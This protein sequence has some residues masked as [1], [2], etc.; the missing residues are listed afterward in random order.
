MI[1][2]V[3]RE[4][5]DKILFSS[6]IKG[7]F[8]CC[9]CGNPTDVSFNGVYVC[10]ECYHYDYDETYGYKSYTPDDFVTVLG[11]LILN[12]SIEFN[13]DLLICK[14]CRL[15]YDCSVYH[16]LM[17]LPKIRLDDSIDNF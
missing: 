9:E 15:F 16:V 7:D 8:V 5:N 2:Y 12:C 10:E 6:N 14:D 11:L 3:K 4:K 13:P 1:K 17:D